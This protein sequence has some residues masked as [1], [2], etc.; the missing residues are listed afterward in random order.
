MKN[1]INNVQKK[2]RFK[3]VIQDLYTHKFKEGIHMIFV[4]KSILQCERIYIKNIV[5]M[6]EK[7]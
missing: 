7:L 3:K 4:N 6:K 2:T 5:K 1:F